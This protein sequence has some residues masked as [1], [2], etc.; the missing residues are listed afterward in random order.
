MPAPWQSLRVLI[1]PNAT[2]AVDPIDLSGPYSTLQFSTGL[3]GGFKLLRLTVP[4]PLGEIWEYL[5]RHLPGRHFFH[6]EIVEAHTIVWEGRILDIGFQMSGNRFLLDLTA[7]GYVN[8]LRDQ[9]YDAADASNTDWTSGSHSADDV[10]KE[11]LT[12]E[13]P[14]ISSDQSNIAATT[15]DIGGLVL[16]DRA[17]PL[18]IITSKIAPLSDTSNQ[19]WH[20]AVWE[21]QTAYWSP[22][23][24][25]QVDVIVTLASLSQLR[26]TQS[27]MHLR[28]AVQPVVGATEGTADDDDDSLVL[29][30]RRELLLKLPTG[31]SATVANAAR[32]TAIAERKQPRQSTSFTINGPVYSTEA[33]PGL[34]VD[35][36]IAE[37]PKWRV[38]AGKVIRI[39]D[40]VPQGAAT[41]AFDDLRTF[42]IVETN[43]DAVSD[44][45]RIQPDRPANT[46][47]AILARLNLLERDY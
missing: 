24:L 34:P 47:S 8:S 2:K 6:I 44:T 46:L 40:L 36:A 25:D 9:Y 35:G 13:C 17:Y 33:A 37:I 28:N 30:P 20:F 14:D 12:K 5:N 31:V 10:I 23:S 29:Y 18:D 38:R 7:A 11:L 39:Q 3:H 43:Y 19:V 21:N 16:T 15:H 4:M 26:L 42:H 27:A 1:Y 41:T 32:D 45:L 22:R